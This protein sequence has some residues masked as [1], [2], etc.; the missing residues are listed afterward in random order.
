MWRPVQADPALISLRGRLASSFENIWKVIFS[1]I[2]PKMNG[3]RP[4]P[5]T[6]SSEGAMPVSAGW[7]SRM[8][9]EFNNL[10][11]ARLGHVRH[12]KLARLLCTP[13][14][15]LFAPAR[16]INSKLSRARWP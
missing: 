8:R 4:C 1:C 10:K 9:A 13:K 7:Q 3:S 5:I 15:E 6:V 12:F 2:S 11:L 16:N 14:V